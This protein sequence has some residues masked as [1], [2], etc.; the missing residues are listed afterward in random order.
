MS[1]E[2]GSR[3]S[4]VGREDGAPA[5][6][7][8]LRIEG[9]YKAYDQHLVLKNIN[10]AVDEHEVVC[11]IGAS[12]CGKSTLLRCI[13]LLEEINA[14]AIYLGDELITRE[15]IDADRVRQRIGLVFQSFNLFPHMSVLENIILAPTKALGMGRREATE[16]ALALLARFGLEDK[17]REYPDRL[18]GGQQQRVAIIRALALNPRVLLLDEVTSALDPEMVGEVLNVIAELKG[19]G[20]TMILATHQMGF[21]YQIADRVAFLEAGAILEEGPARRMLSEPE[22]PRTRQFLQ[23]V[24]AAAPIAATAAGPEE[25]AMA[26]AEMAPFAERG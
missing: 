15:G 4:E 5:S 13:N 8:L 6:Q 16:A 21:A 17:A 22:H 26:F 23:Q 12:G 19:L 24:L 10:L 7:A 18:S 20:M 2:A 9:L 1:A 14:G 25:Q 11:L 3:K